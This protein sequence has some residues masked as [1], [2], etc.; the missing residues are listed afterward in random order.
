MKDL[1]ASRSALASGAAIAA[2]SLSAV[3]CQ[4]PSVGKPAASVGAA[5]AAAPAS[6]AA[7]TAVTYR[8]APGTS[9]IEFTGSK[10]TGKHDGTFG[11]FSGT[12]SVTGGTPESAGLSVE[13]DLASVKTDNEKL[14]GHLKSPDFFDVARFP[15]ATFTSTAIQAGAAAGTG[16][17]HTV[18]GTL[19]LHGVRRTVSFPA[20]VRVTPE[21]VEAD[22]EFSLNRKDFGIVYPGMPDDL[23]R[24]NVVIRLAIRAPRG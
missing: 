7:A 17:T 4:D 5:V 1:V 16:V 18:T 14:D 22:A 19:D 3:A 9:R 12:A 10:V 13:I 23:I 11:S 6:P 15:K 20:R 24:D 2:L 8:I 21:T